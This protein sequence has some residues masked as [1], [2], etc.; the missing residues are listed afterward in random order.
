[1]VDHAATLRVGD[2]S[3][4]ET[5]KIGPVQNEMQYSKVREY[6]DDCVNHKYKFA[7]GGGNE[8]RDGYFIGPAIIDNPPA[9]SRIVTEEPFGS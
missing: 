3:T 9:D 1:M 5:A 2:S 6:F 4:N 7:F 8:Q